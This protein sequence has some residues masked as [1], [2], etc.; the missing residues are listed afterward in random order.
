[1]YGHDIQKN[2]D[3]I[4]KSR[5]KQVHLNLEYKNLTKTIEN[6]KRFIVIAAVRY[7]R[8]DIL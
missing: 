3:K 8:N 2:N 4:Y 5:Q 1:M 6:T 7:I